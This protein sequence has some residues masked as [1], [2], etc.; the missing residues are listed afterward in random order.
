M[1][2]LEYLSAR[3]KVITAGGTAGGYATIVFDIKW[4][5]KRIYSFSEQFHIWN[6]V[7]TYFLLKIIE[8]M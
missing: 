2:L 6:E 3:Y 7:E 5:A 8:N 1:E 4:K